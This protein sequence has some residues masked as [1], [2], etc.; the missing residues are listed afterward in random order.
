MIK[1]EESFIRFLFSIEQLE[2]P[3]RLNL[4]FFKLLCQFFALIIIISYVISRVKV[5]QLI[6]LYTEWYKRTFCK[7]DS[8]VN[9]MKK[10]Y[11]IVH[12]FSAFSTTDVV[13][14]FECIDMYDLVNTDLT[15]YKAMIISGLV[16]QDF[17]AEEQEIIT[18]FLNDGKLLCFFGNLISSWIPGQKPYEVQ[19]IRWHGDYDLTIENNH[20]IFEG[21]NV[22]EMTSKMG[23]KGIFARGSHPAPEHAEIVVTLPGD[24]TVTFIDRQSTNGTIFMHSGSTFFHTTGMNPQ[25]GL[26]TERI[27]A[28]MMAWAEAE[29][30]AL[31]NRGDHNA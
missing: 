15:P 1:V 18:N 3:L 28:Q 6:I 17:L 16:D 10:D 13:P 19:E 22:D 7:N 4:Q 23:V 5:I 29:C 20:P 9:I 27:P 26:S 30:E 14:P 11:L 31:K 24:K 25:Q 21:V 12:A 2:F 8:E